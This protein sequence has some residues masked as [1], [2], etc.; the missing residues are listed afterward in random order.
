MKRKLEEEYFRCIKTTFHNEN[1]I[2]N[3]QSPVIQTD[4]D[5]DNDED[6]LELLYSRYPSTECKIST[7]DKI[8][9]IQNISL[10][11]P[12]EIW[13][14]HILM[15]LTCC[16][17]NI[18]K[19]VSKH[20]KNLVNY[21][22][23][24]NYNTN[25]IKNNCK[26]IC[27]LS[28]ITFNAAYEGYLSLL[29]WS[30]EN[31]DTKDYYAYY[32]ALKGSNK[33]V[34][35]W[36]K[37]K[38]YSNKDANNE[39][40]WYNAIK[41]GFSTMEWLREYSPLPKIDDQPRKLFKICASTGDISIIE[42]FTSQGF[43]LNGLVWRGATKRG[44]IHI[45]EWIKNWD[46]DQK[47][48]IDILECLKS[49]SAKGHVHV[50]KWFLNNNFIT[51]NDF[52]LKQVYNSGAENGHLNIIQWIYS[53]SNP[54]PRECL[55]IAARNGHMDI[56]FWA[57][58]EGL[59]PIKRSNVNILWWTDIDHGEAMTWSQSDHHPGGARMT[60]GRSPHHRYHEVCVEN[61]SNQNED[62]SLCYSAATSGNLKNLKWLKEKGCLWDEETC[63]KAA[64]EGHLHIL[65]WAREQG[66]PWNCK[67]SS[68]A[69]YYGHINI[70]EWLKTQDYQFDHNVYIKALQENHY[71]IFK[72]ALKNNCPS[73]GI[74]WSVISYSICVFAISRG[75]F[76]VL[77][78]AVENG[79]PLRNT[80]VCAKAASK[81]YLPILKWLR[82]YK[83]PWNEK[84]CYKAAQKGHL[85]VLKWARENNCPWNERTCYK[86]A[87]NGHL[88]VL[89]WA[90][91][92]DCPWNFKT[93]YKASK[94]GHLDVLKWAMNNGCPYNM[95]VPI[96][97]ALK[98]HLHILK[99][100][101]IKCN[102]M[103]LHLRSQIWD[104]KICSEAASNGRASA[105]R[106]ASF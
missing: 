62:Y 23:E 88:N 31:G 26:F 47:I 77:Q 22:I 53:K 44:H 85:D 13:I 71:S 46:P 75:Q 102:Q 94:G 37:K 9:K 70:L 66:C 76:D 81:G 8:I 35:K 32:G 38:E 17:Y 29:E 5:D 10:S 80:D 57:H 43:I 34:L 69:A 52:H 41:G 48:K 90:R 24:N 92:N 95:K 63:S 67:T 101:L 15:F 99:W 83:S 49:A 73:S 78:W 2:T 74:D 54:L 79:C 21:L 11:L 89:Q 33:I 84:T 105:A 50:L 87:R 60:C 93:C 27:I 56:L 25:I 3:N 91:E 16:E 30:R 18:L 59:I 96:Y 36:L 64:C 68:K 97:A 1:L 51:K 6:D 19:L 45:L 86:A 20:V 42:W 39:K 12:N 58:Q 104:K 103:R 98:G 55:S 7:V 106:S 72:W 100:W 4:D 82:I 65:S 40:L 14:N 61:R 28:K